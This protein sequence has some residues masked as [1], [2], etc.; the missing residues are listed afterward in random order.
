MKRILWTIAFVCLF[1][2]PSISGTIPI[3]GTI[4]NSAGNLLNGRIRFTL[5]YSAG[6][7]TCSNNV[8]V[9]Q[10]VEFLVVN[11]TLPSS[12]RIT[13]NDCISPAN[14]VYITQYLGAA[15][16]RLGQNN[17]Y[18]QGASFDIGT[19]TPTPLTTSNISFGSFTGLTNITSKNIDNI[20]MCDQFTGASASA[21]IIACIADLPST[22]GTADARGLE[23]SQTWSACPFTGVT[24]PVFV[25]HGQGTDT[26]SASCSI[27]ANVTLEL[28]C[29]AILSP[30]GGVTITFVRRPVADSCKHFAG[31]GS[32]LVDRPEVQWFGALGDGSTDDAAAFNA[33]LTA[34]AA[35]GTGSVIVPYTGSKYIIASTV[36]LKPGVDLIGS[37]SLGPILRFTGGASTL[38]DFLGTSEAQSFNVTIKNLQL[39]SATTHTGVGIRA[40]NFSGITLDNSVISNFNQG[41]WADWGIGVYVKNNST[42]TGCIRG[43][44]VGGGTGGI[45]G[46]TFATSPFLDTV[47]VRDSHFSQNQIDINDMGSTNTLGGLT[48]ET[49]SFFEDGTVAGKLEMIRVS[50][51]RAFTIKDNWLEQFTAGNVAI[52]FNAFDYDGTSRG[53]PIGGRVSSNLIRAQGGANSTGIRMDRCTACNIS[54]NT[55]WWG[56]A[57]GGW[58]I[59]SEDSTSP[60]TIEDNIFD[61]YSAGGFTANVKQ[62]T[63]Y[64]LFLTTD[65]NQRALGTGGSVCSTGPNF[66]ILPGGYVR[67]WGCVDFTGSATP[68]WTFPKVFSVR[69]VNVF[70]GFTGL[71]SNLY[72]TVNTDLVFTSA[73]TSVQLRSSDN[74]THAA[75]A[76]CT[77]EGF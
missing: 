20:R 11:G 54:N 46:G 41:L 64:A 23:G 21:K 43:L 75:L 31:S 55:F 72:V 16:Q 63:D 68:T 45:R 18:V 58:G 76:S 30:N 1:A 5:S 50:G 6:R 59:D 8:V 47:V 36:T 69:A 77:A 35:L 32:I 74:A 27:P 28:N 51:R 53:S 60:P 44:Q 39:E 9:A 42:I 66:I 4:R 10:T 7:D 14:T 70:C 56:N 2:V 49:T 48:I 73:T 12:A 57:V 24:K 15:G 38:L 34:A 19:A 65:T 52:L 13:P 62:A 3:S 26:I 29:G 33:G 22:G 25:R 67:Q 37:G 71:G 40:R 17:F 61:T